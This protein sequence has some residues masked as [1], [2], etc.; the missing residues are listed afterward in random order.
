MNSLPIE[1]TST[2][3]TV[4]VSATD[5]EG[6]NGS[7]PSGVASIA[8]YD[9]TNGGSF[10]LF[11]TVTPSD[12]SATF[13]GQAGKTY[14]FYSI[15]T[16]NA[17]NVQPTPTAAQQTVQILNQMTISSIAAVAHRSSG[18]IHFDSRRHL[19][20]ADQHHD[21]TRCSHPDRQRPD[22]SRRPARA[23]AGLGDTY[24]IKWAR[25]PDLRRGNVHPHR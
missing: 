12:P 20:L 3:F 7:T 10:A 13:T 9:S 14:S 25:F 16:D 24:Q 22:R 23:Y 17:G 2:S 6:A 8:I 4:S 15:A 11:T 21:L 19:Q 1:T 5:P 18:Y